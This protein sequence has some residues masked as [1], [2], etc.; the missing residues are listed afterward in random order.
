MIQIDCTLSY[1]VLWDS[2]MGIPRSSPAWL[3][4][5][6]HST[7][8]EDWLRDKG[9]WWVV[10]TATLQGDSGALEPS[11]LHVHHPGPVPWRRGPGQPLLRLPCYHP[12]TNALLGPI[13]AS[14]LS[15]IIRHGRSKTR[16]CCCPRTWCQGTPCVSH[17][18]GPDPP[19]LERPSFVHCC[20]LT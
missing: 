19:L 4:P 13:S 6:Q 7:M 10:A 5:L 1:E 11:A 3:N 17:V 2:G 12:H 14:F 8:L 16:P 20:S 18:P 9:L 15:G